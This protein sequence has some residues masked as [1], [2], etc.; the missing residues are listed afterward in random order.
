MRTIKPV[1]IALVAASL[2]LLNCP[3]ASCLQDEG[4]RPAVGGSCPAVYENGQGEEAQDALPDS[5][6]FSRAPWTRTFEHEGGEDVDEDALYRKG[7]LTEEES[8]ILETVKKSL[9]ASA[10]SDGFDIPVVLNDAVDLYIKYFTGTGRKLF[11]H[12]L[13]RA[14][15]YVPTIRAVLKKNGLPEDLVYLA[16]IESGFN[17]KAYSPEEG[18]GTLAVYP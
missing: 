12:W 6:L 4:D 1:F 9:A 8:R 17:M 2:F 5:P 7:E 3:Q 14:K 15:R 13:E 10:V 11:A 18:K 16:M